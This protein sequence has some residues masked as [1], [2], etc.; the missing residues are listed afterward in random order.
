MTDAVQDRL[1]HG[2]GH[3]VRVAE[4]LRAHGWRVQDFGQGLFDDDIR[5]AMRSARIELT[6]WWRWIPD[7][8]AAKG[9]RVVLVD[10]KTDLNT[11]TPNF[12]IE[13][14]AWWAHR[15]MRMLGLPIVYVWSDFTCNLVELLR[16]TRRLPG[17]TEDRTE[18]YLV[19]KSDQ[20][21]F[22]W[23]F[24]ACRRIPGMCCPKKVV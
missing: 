21:P 9:S 3:E 15:Q 13:V 20:Q 10:P 18:F 5:I 6:V 4:K 23:A 2:R 22:E 8:V 24:D 17:V 16:P 12:S 1:H 19:A 7:L 11:T 14:S